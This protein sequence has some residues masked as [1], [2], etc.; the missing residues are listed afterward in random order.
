MLVTDNYAQRQSKR[1]SLTV[2]RFTVDSKTGGSPL[3]EF[4]PRQTEV[5][6]Q[7]LSLIQENGLAGLTMRKVAERMGFSE[8]AMYRHF[9]TKQDLVLGIISRLE[10][11]LIHPMR[12]IVA[13]EEL[14]VIERIA[15]VV[16]HH[17]DLIAEKN[18]LPILLFAEAAAS[19]DERLTL[20]MRGVFSAYENLLIQLLQEGQAHGEIDPN[21]NPADGAILLMGAPTA[22]ALRMRLFSETSKKS[23]RQR[24]VQYI[25]SGILQPVEAL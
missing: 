1:K 22:C 4:T 20:A 18:G 2:K 23:R 12:A 21:L 11:S 3:P 6:N 24:L 9:S 5:L 14:A 7:S 8:P 10:A 13:K 16:N 25:K 19:A 15:A 17:L